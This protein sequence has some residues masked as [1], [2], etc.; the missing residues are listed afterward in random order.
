[1]RNDEVVSAAQVCTLPDHDCLR[2]SILHHVNYSLGLTPEGLQPA[3]AFR[4][5]SLAIRDLMVERSL[6][7]DS[8]FCR[9]DSKRLYYLSL[10]FLIGRSLSNNILNLQL[11]PFAGVFEKEKGVK[12]KFFF[13]LESALPSLCARR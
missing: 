10:E 5:V 2:S 1:M 8:E 9:N 13:A 3:E 12:E 6:R 4:A 7:T 11:T